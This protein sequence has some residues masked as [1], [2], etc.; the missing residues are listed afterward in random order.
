MC[1]YMYVCGSG[2]PLAITGADWVAAARYTSRISPAYLPYISLY[3]WVSAACYI[4]LHLPY[5][6][7]ISL[8]LWVAAARV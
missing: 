1:I 4:S 5:L 7:Y 6:P 8:Y 2:C 3:L